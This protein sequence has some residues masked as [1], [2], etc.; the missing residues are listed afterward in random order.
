MKCT[1]TESG[2][3]LMAVC[4]E[5]N[6]QMLMMRALSDWMQ[7]QQQECRM[8]MDHY[9]QSSI[10]SLQDQLQDASHKA[11]MTDGL[12]NELDSAK[13]RLN[14]LQNDLEVIS[15]TIHIR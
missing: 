4:L 14:Q 1:R 9:A 2:F 15:H 8:L 5:K 12:N 11:L 3:K 13:S 10:R 7:N 6:R